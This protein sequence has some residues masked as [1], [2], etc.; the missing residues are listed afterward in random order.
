[1]SH[2]NRIVAV[3]VAALCVAACGSKPER[4]QVDLMDRSRDI[5]LILRYDTNNDRVISREEMEAG[6]KR[7][8]DAA[9]LNHDG[10]LTQD[11]VQ[12]ENQRRWQA[13]GPQSS[14]LMDWNMDGNIS[15]TEFA[16]AVHSLFAMIDRDKDNT[17]TVKEL[18][19]PRGIAPPTPR[20]D[21]RTGVPGG[22]QSPQTQPGQVPT[23]GTY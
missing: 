16:G 12:A 4:A 17:V 3:A 21:P 23:G 9:D 13:E 19:A 8:Y 11:E 2:I 1:M 15:M 20:L 7:D 22:A 18:Q 5:F 6:L 10:K 14:P